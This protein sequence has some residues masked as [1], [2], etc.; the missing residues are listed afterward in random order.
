MLAIFALGS[1]AAV[2]D[3]GAQVKACDLITRAEAAQVLAKPAVASAQ[4][5]SPD[6]EDCGYLGSGMDVHTELLKNAAGWTAAMKNQIKQGKA[7]AVDGIGEEAAY[8]KDGNHDYVLVT[9][10]ANRIVTVTLYSANWSEADAKPKLIKLA[11]LAV[12]KV[13]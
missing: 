10:K 7:E 4:A 2:A 9:R 8:T 3:A 6:D 5:V 11:T 12:A 13:R 1:S